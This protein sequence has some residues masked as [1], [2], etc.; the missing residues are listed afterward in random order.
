MPNW[1]SSTTSAFQPLFPRRGYVVT[2]SLL[3]VQVLLWAAMLVMGVHPLFPDSSA[4]LDWGANLG[5]RVMDGE[6]WRLLSGGFLHAGAAQLALNMAVLAVLGMSLEWR[7]GYVRFLLAYL[8][9]GL[10]A[11]LG[12]A[13]LSGQ[14]VSVG[15]AGS[16]FGL[17][18]V[19]VSLVMLKAIPAKFKRAALVL[20]PL[21]LLANLLNFSFQGVDHWANFCGF[22]AGVLLGPFLRIGMRPVKPKEVA[23]PEPAPV[24]E[25]QI[26]I[27]PLVIVDPA[28]GV[29][30]A[31]EAAEAPADLLGDESAEIPAEEVL[32]SAA[33][34][35][36]VDSDDAADEPDPELDPLVLPI[37]GELNT[38]GDAPTA[39]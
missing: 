5:S 34:P 28:D 7:M 11:G 12:S 26:V 14:I 32:A 27:P 3:A 18:G 8:L 10:C 15:A 9:C 16:L 31:E 1:L 13:Y 24:A 21:F 22:T 35:L 30:E 17:I 4:L 6:V 39:P 33:E 38:F 2:P 29:A 23:A 19:Q 37:P 25:A 36:V 20:L